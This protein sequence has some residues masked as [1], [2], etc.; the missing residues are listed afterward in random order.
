MHPSDAPPAPW[1]RCCRGRC[2]RFCHRRRRRR[3]VY[4][5][6]A[7]SDKGRRN[8]NAAAAAAAAIGFAPDA[9]LGPFPGYFVPS[10]DAHASEYIAPCHER[11]AFVSGFT[12]SAG[13]AVVTT[14]AAALWTDGKS[15]SNVGFAMSF[16]T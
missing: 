11:R 16:A 9:H 12:G 14:T 13:T 6:R 15:I 1:A 3:R 4:H 5:C 8:A 2:R 10:E 7:C